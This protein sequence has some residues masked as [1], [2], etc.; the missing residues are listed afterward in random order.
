[1]W[2]T[3][4]VDENVIFV[5]MRHFALILAAFAALSC[6]PRPQ[7][8]TMTQL[9]ERVFRLACRQTIYMDSLL[10]ARQQAPDAVLCPRTFQGDSLVTSDIGWWCSGFYPGLLWQV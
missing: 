6:G 3:V 8:E 5:V 10:S 2:W 4:I 7:E 1:M 9:A